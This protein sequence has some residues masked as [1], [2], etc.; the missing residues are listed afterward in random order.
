MKK[1]A[2][3]KKRI[4]LLLGCLLVMGLALGV[5]YGLRARAAAS[6]T[7]TKKAG[8]DGNTKLGI[9]DIVVDGAS[10]S[11]SRQRNGEKNDN[12]YF[13]S[14]V[15]LGKDTNGA[16]LKF[17]VIN[18]DLYSD[19][20]G[21]N[22]LKDQ[23]LLLDCMSVLGTSTYTENNT[24][25]IDKLNG[26]AF[27]TNSLT[28]TEKNAILKRTNSS[29]K[30]EEAISLPWYLGETNKIDAPLS[31]LLSMK[32]MYSDSDTK[33]G[34]PCW[35]RKENNTVGYVNEIGEYSAATTSNSQTSGISPSLLLNQKKIL[36][37]TKIDPDG[38]TDVNNDQKE[39]A[40]YRLDSIEKY[41][42]KDSAYKLTLIDDKLTAKVTEKKSVVVDTTNECYKVTIP[43]TVSDTTKDD[44]NTSLSVL[45][46]NGEW[47]STNASIVSYTQ[48]VNKVDSSG[49]GMVTFEL[50]KEA[51]TNYCNG[52]YYV[53]LIAEKQSSDYSVDVAS[54][55]EKLTITKKLSSIEMIFKAPMH[56][57]D[58]TSAST[59]ITIGELCDSDTYIDLKITGING[60]D[61]SNDKTLESLLTTCGTEHNCGIFLKDM[62][63]KAD[64]N[65]KYTMGLGLKIEN[66]TQNNTQNQYSF[67]DTVIINLKIITG[68][69]DTKYTTEKIE[70]SNSGSVTLYNDTE[71]VTLDNTTTDIHFNFNFTTRKAK[72]LGISSPKLS[73]KDDL[74][75]VLY[76]PTWEKF[77][78]QLKD[79]DKIA[80][81][82]VEKITDGV[83]INN[84]IE[85]IPISWQASISDKFKEN[86]TEGQTFSIWGNL[87][88]KDSQPY[89]LNGNDKV[90]A[91][92][93]MDRQAK[94]PTPIVYYFNDKQINITNSS[95]QMSGE[96]ATI[97]L[98]VPKGAEMSS[99]DDTDA[100][101][102]YTLDGSAPTTE[103]GTQ[104]NR[105]T[106]IVLSEETC[107]KLQ[108]DEKVSFTLKAMAI[109]DDCV[110]SDVSSAATI[111]FYKKNNITVKNATIKDRTEEKRTEAQDENTHIY[112]VRGETKI[113]LVPE[114]KSKDGKE[115]AGW[116]IGNSDKVQTLTDNVYTTGTEDTT[117]E[118]VYNT[119]E[120]PTISTNPTKQTVTDGADAEFSVAV[121]SADL[122]RYKDTLTYQW[123]KKAVGA[124][125]FEELK[126]S[127]GTISGATTDKLTLTGV[128][129]SQ[130]GE[131]YRCIVKYKEID[132]DGTEKEAG[133]SPSESATLTVTKANKLTI[134]TDPKDVTIKEKTDASFTVEAEVGYEGDSL[135]Y[136]WQKAEKDSED[137]I[138][139]YG[140][141]E[142]GYTV[143]E[144]TMDDNGTKYRCRVKEVDEESA[145]VASK[146]SDSASLT[147]ENAYSIDITKQPENASVSAGKSATFSVEASSFYEM[148]YEWQADYHDGKGYQKVGSDS[149]YTLKKATKD[150][151]G[152]TFKCIISL[153]ENPETTVTSQEVVLNV[154]EAD[155]TVTVNKGSANPESCKAGDTVTIKAENAEEG[156][157][158]KKWKV[159]KGSVNLEDATSA[160]TSF[161]MPKE[162]V[163]L[164]AVYEEGNDIQI[165]SQPENASVASGKSAAFSVEATSS[166]ELV[167]EWQAD[168]HD[169]KGYQKVG[170]DSTYTIKKVTKDLSG[171]TF[172]CI[173]S[174]K[175]NSDITVTSQEVVLN[176]DGADYTV[177]VNKGSASPESCKAGDTVTIKAEDA[178]EGMAFKKWKVVKGDVK[179]EDASSA[180][181]T[182]V[183]PKEDVELTAVYK[184][185]SDI[186]ITAQPESTSIPE[187]GSVSFTV[188]ATSSH[189]LSYQWQED[190][191]DG[192]GFQNVGGNEESYTISSVASDLN[193]ARYQCIITAKDDEEMTITSSEAVL[194][195]TASTYTI[196]V[197]NGSGSASESVAGE[198]ITVTANDAPE[199]QE[200]EKW[201]VVRGKANL[202]DLTSKETTF[203]MP[204]ANVELDVKYRN[205]IDVP[206]ISKQPQ[207]VTVYA[208]SSTSFTVEAS[209]EEI[210]YQWQVDNGDGSGF[211]DISG[212]TSATYRV[213]TED[214]SMNG[215]RYQCL[216]SNREGSATS[217]AATL[218]VSY[219]ITQGAGASWQK[220]SSS[221]LTFKG[222]G[223]YD[224]FKSVKVD[225]ERVSGSNFTKSA[226]P[227]VITLAATYLQ[228]LTNGT[229]TLTI[230]WEDGTAEAEFSVSGTATS[231]SSTT[232]SS[233][234]GSSS[235]GNT[236]ASASSSSD[237]AKTSDTGSTKET[238]TTDMPIVNKSKSSTGDTTSK[239][240][241]TTNRGNSGSTKTL[242]EGTSTGSSRLNRYAA[243]ISL[244]VVAA[245]G[246]GGGVTL[247]VRRSIRRKDD[248]DMF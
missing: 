65:T 47:N 66:N 10:M 74:I 169:G 156:K 174:L 126:D 42:Y 103:T 130:N 148:V 218:T 20:Q 56:N 14:Y 22:L 127:K 70:V 73:V 26:P 105:K 112:K 12:H 116:K 177:T 119:L 107:N 40:R 50:G 106:G 67:D 80:E 102:Y 52:N 24:S 221:G 89:D 230:V 136:Q 81:V 237:K 55:P 206:T 190:K 135:T 97:Y 21:T 203:T 5:G 114:D 59:P 104:Y 32:E 147:V 79:D 28:E 239:T 109:E 98:M 61:F 132:K 86:K 44:R 208:G 164:T 46:T 234:G 246:L 235:S 180:E 153:K 6:Q 62:S 64:F 34:N 31:K 1:R 111:V 204:A 232:A 219:K 75:D 149:S 227:T 137:F 123:Q 60:T 170:S 168:Y 151:N 152:T 139:I 128:A 88:L 225:G 30:K 95:T 33:K 68:D 138:D 193:G 39:E 187:G 84:A 202:A 195:V 131:E 17:Q 4:R 58:W 53:Y 57:D 7:I 214:C 144:A 94:V 43:Y 220:N 72:V 76:A 90:Y 201:V 113:T 223:A 211:Q 161:V 182:F 162:D 51:Y 176:V 2:L 117:I 189:E 179:L 141:T 248:E 199:G 183:M 16:P 197:N 121:T 3:K 236:S 157:V 108:G 140:A 49:T 145:E 69:D 181:T 185:E 205:Q 173:I 229:H 96:S 228:D 160:E 217:D 110:N 35:V 245:C 41:L 124:K 115:F 216:V 129:Y 163:E 224:K 154:D 146:T 209:G 11:A 48:V 178:E 99:G 92:V 210:S 172:K 125:D 29:T 159:V 143:S 167:Y 93:S 155:Y 207:S 212:A 77:L 118:A 23:A 142:A 194:T 240:T 19:S 122:D 191:G 101:I 25:V 54:K 87:K 134:K 71:E 171:T 226:D 45:V 27:Y 9:G 37:S 18:K 213:Y 233:S 15:Y 38:Q 175:E 166:H 78:S 231:S 150:L 120:V 165:T 91:D 222:S 238:G 83:Y 36:F 247:L 82:T 85:E 243:M 63:Q 196:K 133:K 8:N 200:F 192:N 242:G 184:E 100:T 186:Q 158:F 198:V 244:I 13:R 215:Y 188:T 241:G